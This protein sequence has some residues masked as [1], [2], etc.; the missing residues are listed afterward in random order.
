MA[1]TG[2]QMRTDGGWAANLDL[3]L[4]ALGLGLAGAAYLQLLEP[5]HSVV[6]LSAAIL[7]VAGSTYG[8]SLAARRR[9][10]LEALALELGGDGTWVYDLRTNQIRYDDR[11][12]AML[13]YERGHVAD[14]LSA[15]GK[16]VHPDDLEPARK[17]LDAFIEGTSDR[18]EAQVRLRDVRGCW[19]RILDRGRVVRRDA[20]GKP[21][22]IVGVHRL[23]SGV[24]PEA[25]AASASASDMRGTARWL[26]SETD[27][28]LQVAA[29]KLEAQ[30]RHGDAP[31]V[32][33]LSRA[34]DLLRRYRALDGI[35]DREGESAEIAKV[36]RAVISRQRMLVPELAVDARLSAEMRK[37]AA[38]EAVLA[39]VLTLVIDALGAPDDAL[40][41]IV[42]RQGESAGHGPTLTFE[43][44]GAEVSE[45][46][47]RLRAASALLR[48]VDGSLEVSG[49]AIALHLPAA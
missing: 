30:A 29:R 10:D 47:P 43:R 34:R 6:A 24:G 23:L 39:E 1:S 35:V 9:P 16:L 22:L 13:G 2:L 11:C 32:D 7:V 26:L 20:T 42:V 25:D 21:T 41:P 36:L 37:V 17:A 5:L 33:T 4:A 31:I 44:E 49:D 46:L 3:G 12:G 45:H 8:A 40:A 48:M 19:R 38:D 15:W 14:R 18:Y 28:E 27:D